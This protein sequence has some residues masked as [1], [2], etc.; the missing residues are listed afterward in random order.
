MSNIIK[1]THQC[2]SCKETVYI[3]ALNN[4]QMAPCFTCGKVYVLNT[5]N[6]KLEEW[7]PKFHTDA[8]CQT[9]RIMT[10]EMYDK[11]MKDVEVKDD[12]N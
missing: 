4:K 2:P 1:V 10:K 9:V 3:Q 7:K 6:F 12:T 5:D 8:K 11:M